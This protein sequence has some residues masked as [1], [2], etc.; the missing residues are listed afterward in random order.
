MICRVDKKEMLDMVS[1][2]D[3]VRS[4]EPKPGVKRAQEIVREVMEMLES[5]DGDHINMYE[6]LEYVDVI[7]D[8]HV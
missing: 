7:L 3:V 6:N 2:K 4:M 8:Y 1:M 5:G